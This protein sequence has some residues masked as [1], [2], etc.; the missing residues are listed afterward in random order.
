MKPLV[1]TTLTLV[2]VTLAWLTNAASKREFFEIKVYTIENNE[3]E[4]VL[5]EFLKNA[6]LPALHRAGIN[7]VGVFKPVESDTVY[8]GKR[9]YVII[10]FSSLDQFASLDATL[11]KDKAYLQAGKAYIDAP[12]NNPPYARMESIVLQAFTYMPELEPPKLSSPPSERV[13]ELRSYEGHTEKIYKNK[14]KMFNEGGEVALFKRLGF[15]AIFYAEVLA[16][17]RM[18]NLMYMTSFEN[19]AA[20]DEH[21]KTFSNDAEWKKLKA[22][23]EYQNNVVRN[24][25]FLLHPTAYSDL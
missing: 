20:R 11:Q 16:G 19:R 22:M 12:Y 23:P 6:Y 15:N 3:Q 13:Y 18:P 7:R 4:K 2:F 8:F 21:W 17:S 1:T 9:M 10:P 14:V 25:I 5:D 24:N